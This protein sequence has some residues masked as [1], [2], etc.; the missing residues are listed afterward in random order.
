MVYDVCTT[1]LNPDDDDDEGQSDYDD[2]H[3]IGVTVISTEPTVCTRVR[4]GAE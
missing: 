2:A 3:C 1:F 4:R